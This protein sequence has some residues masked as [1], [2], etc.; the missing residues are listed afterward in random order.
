MARSDD[1]DDDRPRKK[2]PS[3][4]VDDV[5][6]D[7]ADRPRKKKPS[8]DVDDAD[9][10]DDDRP[11]KKKPSRDVDEDDVD[12]D[13][14]D[15]PRRKARPSDDDDDDEDDED[16]PR[17]KKRSRDDDDDDDVEDDDDDD[18]R[19][20][21]KRRSRD[22]DEDD[23]DD[24]EDRPRKKKKKKKQK[25]MPGMLMAFAIVNMAWGGLNT[26]YGLYNFVEAIHAMTSVM[27]ADQLFRGFGAALGLSKGFTITISILFFFILVGWAVTLGG[28]VMLILRKGMGKYLALG[29]PIIVTLMGL[30]GLVVT[31]IMTHGTL[32]FGS[33]L[34]AFIL[35][36]VFAL[37]TAIFNF[38][39]GNND[40]VARALR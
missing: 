28:G 7:D 1:D 5:D 11:R 22:E 19:P 15:R 20:R 14:E 38:I 4:D 10:D 26:L 2:K 30:I 18:D 39:A 3:R 36:I 40:D 27:A 34:V 33:Y 17:K 37:A 16:R 9:D 32:V 13:D 6:E 24:E 25:A 8:R 12:E 21:K 29:G 23:D 31:I 35:I